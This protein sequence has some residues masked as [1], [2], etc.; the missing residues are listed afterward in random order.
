MISVTLSGTATA[1]L[2]YAGTSNQYM[3]RK[4][5]LLN[6]HRLVVSALWELVNGVLDSES[7]RRGGMNDEQER[8]APLATIQEDTKLDA[9][10]TSIMIEVQ[11]STRSAKKN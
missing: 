11:E 9:S 10:L 6:M 7:K 5:D 3:R 2:G 4:P 1:M 8:S